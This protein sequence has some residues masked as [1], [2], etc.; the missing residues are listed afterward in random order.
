[1]TNGIKQFLIKHGLQILIIVLTGFSV[2]ILYRE[3]VDANAVAIVKMD[4]RITE[5]DNKYPSSEWFNLRFQYIDER[6]GDLENKIDGRAT[7]NRF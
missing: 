5:V 3:K 4:E 7:I 2:V 6:I 1:M